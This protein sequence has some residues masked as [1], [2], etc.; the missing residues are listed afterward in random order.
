MPIIVVGVFDKDVDTVA[1]IGYGKL[2]NFVNKNF[3][4]TFR[5]AGFNYPNNIF[6]K[7]FIQH[8]SGETYYV[9]S[10]RVRPFFHICLQRIF[11]LNAHNCG[12]SF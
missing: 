5:V 6:P 12:W 7:Y 4:K 1:S 3:H 9:F 11:H 2:L 8:Y 10:D